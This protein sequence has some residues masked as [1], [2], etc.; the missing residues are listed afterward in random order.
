MGS[1]PS[2]ARNVKL[3]YFDI[4]V[5]GEP[6]RMILT[7]GGI[8]FEDKRVDPPFKSDAWQSIKSSEYQECVHASCYL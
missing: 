8:K 1:S 4:K 6:I 2:K 3:V 7:Y 5:R